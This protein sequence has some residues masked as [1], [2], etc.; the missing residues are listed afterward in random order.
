MGGLGSL[1]NA[2]TMPFGIKLF[3]GGDNARKYQLSAAKYAS[4]VAQ[5]WLPLLSQTQTQALSALDLI[6]QAST[7]AGAL[8]QLV[9]DYYSQ[10]P[11]QLVPELQKTYGATMAGMDYG[12]AK[13][14]DLVAAQLAARGVLPNSPAFHRIMAL[15]MA[16]LAG[17]RA[18]AA[19]GTRSQLLQT[20]HGTLGAALA[21]V[22]TGLQGVLNS[23]SQRLGL[24]QLASQGVLSG[25]GQTLSAGQALHQGQE[26]AYSRLF[27]TIGL[28]MGVPFL[29]GGNRQLPGPP[30][31]IW[32]TPGGAYGG[33][34]GPGGWGGIYPSGPNP[35]VRPLGTGSWR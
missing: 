9:R 2:I 1:I 28:L 34:Y 33:G 10:S 18:Q 6:P 23:I 31:A 7:M 4:D 21:N 12:L 17:Q 5:S 16:N 27:G 13:T 22:G 14:R 26:D 35:W 32:E 25:A 19:A 15:T 29:G 20:Q 3:P 24:H 11:F 30:V 8:G